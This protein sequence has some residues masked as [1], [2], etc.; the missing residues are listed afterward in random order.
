MNK[1]EIFA[2]II[3]FSI[4]LYCFIPII[5]SENDKVRYY[6]EWSNYK[7]KIELEEA[8]LRLRQL[9]ELNK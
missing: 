5:Q 4:L 6:R 1:S 8:K 7:H 3:V 2:L 9:K